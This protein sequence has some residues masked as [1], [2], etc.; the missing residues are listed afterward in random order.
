MLTWL[1]S[2]AG[3]GGIAAALAFIPGAL[4]L[5]LRWGKAAIDLVRNHPW[6]AAF[7]LAL[8]WGAYERHQHIGWRDFGQSVIAA[9]HKAAADQ[10][11]VN[12]EPVRK[13]AA[14]A[15]ESDAKAPAYYRSVH[16]A[17][18]AHAVRLR[19]PARPVGIA[20]LPG[21]DRPEPSLHG[22]AV[23]AGQ[24]G[25]DLVCRS[26]VEDHW[27]IGAAARAA[28]MHQEALD[29]ISEG[30]AVASPAH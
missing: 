17:A 9:Q 10:I 16:A 24:P 2:L 8:L 11:A 6:Q 28:E 12:H 22:P 15:E 26:A 14:I 25:A 4:P 23:D 21:T 13:S 7:L 1:L 29:L 20:D 30:V 18:D 27:L 19:A 5:A 3:L